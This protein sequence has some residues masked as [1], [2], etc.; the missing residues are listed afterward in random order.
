MEYILIILCLIII[1]LTV[2]SKKA[3]GLNCVINLTE[4]YGYGN[5]PSVKEL[6]KI[7]RKYYKDKK[8]GATYATL[9]NKLSTEGNF[10]DKIRRN[11]HCKT[12]RGCWSAKQY[13]WY[14]IRRFIKPKCW[15]GE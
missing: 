7:M 11:I 2:F 5:E 1:Y 15:R 13:A 6:D 14:D 12:C 9:L 8:N 3:K 10:G 4:V